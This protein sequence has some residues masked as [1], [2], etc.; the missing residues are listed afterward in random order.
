MCLFRF[1]ST[2]LM[3]RKLETSTVGQKKL[4]TWESLRSRKRLFFAGK[5]TS[6]AG[7]K[8]V[9]KTVQTRGGSRVRSSVPFCLYSRK[10]IL[11]G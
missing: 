2:I 8:T 9:E 11:M 4:R 3:T 5:Y 10:T 7:V 1:R 6:Q